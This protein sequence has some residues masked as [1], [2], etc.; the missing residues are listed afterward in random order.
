MITRFLMWLVGHNYY[1]TACMH[2][3][4]ARCRDTCKYCHRPC[5]CKCHKEK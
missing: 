1:S 4:H 3:E 5:T 2:K